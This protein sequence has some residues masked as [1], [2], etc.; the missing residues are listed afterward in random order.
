MLTDYFL[1][2]GLSFF[3]SG[4]TQFAGG[5]FVAF[6]IMLM[7]GRPFVHLMRSMQKKGQ[8]I[9]ENVPS[10]HLQK[11]G[12]PTMGGILIVIAILAGSLLF[13]PI[14]NPTGWIALAA[15]VMFGVLGFIDDYKKV[16]SQSRKSSN[17]LSPLTRL[18]VE[19]VF[20]IILAYLINKTMPPYIPEYSLAIGAGI[21]LP[22][23]LGIYGMVFAIMQVRL[24]RKTIGI[25]GLISSTICILTSI[26][27]VVFMIIM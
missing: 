3:A 24:N 7:F 11:S 13:M 19:G 1:D 5:F 22:F 15:L 10:V 14:S 23:V 27:M 16:T 17:G 2:H 8:P 6:M 9:S 26:A 21:I 18:V 25:V 20:V 12:T 4:W